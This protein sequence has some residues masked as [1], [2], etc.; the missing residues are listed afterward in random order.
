MRRPP[1]LFLVLLLATSLAAGCFSDR[2]RVRLEVAWVAGAALH[3]APAEEVDGLP[4]LLVLRANVSVG[5]AASI[6]LSGLGATITLDE[7]ERALTPLRLTVDGEAHD[8]QAGDLPI[9]HLTEGTTIVLAFVPPSGGPGR[10]PPGEEVPVRVEL[11]WRFDEGLHFDAGRL[12]LERNLTATP[13]PGLGT[14]AAHVSDGRLELLVFPRLEGADVSGTTT[15]TLVRYG[16]GGAE[17]L[18]PI[19]LDLQQ[20]EG[21]VLADPTPK[22]RLPDGPG[23]LVVS[24][25]EGGAVV[26]PLGEVEARTPGPGAGLV[27]ILV[28]GVVGVRRLLVSVR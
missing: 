4:A 15:G 25:P 21:V 17:R 5:G 26:V 6:E 14:G 1:V 11:R 8:P 24:L 16:P 3:A 23:H 10:L 12:V 28:G 13:L 20:G 9:L 2:E 19:Q 27:L 18:S 22:V 7:V